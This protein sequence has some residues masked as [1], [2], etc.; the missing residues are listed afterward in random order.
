M[1]VTSTRLGQIH[2]KD[3]PGAVSFLAIPYA[4]PPVG[5]RRWMPPEPAEPWQGVLDATCH[6][7]RSFQGAWPEDLLPP[8]GIPGDYSEDMLYL[9]VHTPAADGARRPVMVY[10]HGGGYTLGSAND[11][12]PSPYAARHDVVVVAINYRLG[13]FGF[14]DL[15]R[16]GPQYHGSAN[17]GFQ[18]QIAALR[19]VHDNIADFGGDPDNITVCGCS[20]GGGSMV[21]LLAA[22]S[23]KGLFQRGIAMSP[24]EVSIAPPDVVTPCAAAMSMTEEQFFAHIAAMSAEDLFG[25]QAAAGIGTTACVDGHVIMMPTRDAV[26]AGINNVPIL[27]GCTVAEGPMLT[28]GVINAMGSDPAIFALLEG[29][30]AANAGG[31]DAAR[32]VAFLDRMA[33]GA[34]PEQ[35]LDR[36]WYDYFRSFA[37]RTAESLA[38][39][40]VDSWLYEFAAPTEHPYG[41]THGTDVMFVFNA[42]ANMAEGEERAY[43]R[44]TAETRARADLWSGMFA[45]FVRTGRPGDAPCG[46]WPTY[47][48]DRRLSMKLEHDA[49]LVEDFDGPDARSAYGMN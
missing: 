48:R 20:A 29:G 26:L 22:P 45:G 38:D 7:N 25:F 34:T 23:A 30:M 37:V 5:D 10:I 49:T 1:T 31:G 13:I 15:S 32:Y 12:D 21:T 47:G 6:P 27:A 11:F 19:W 2:G 39:A 33:A 40:G 3:M 18:D 46:A 24:L 14:L 43:Y 28:A 17:L 16:F 41:P 44:N 36:L 4:M 42:F 9:N 8:G 35:R